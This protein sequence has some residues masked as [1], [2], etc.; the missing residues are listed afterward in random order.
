MQQV[1]RSLCALAFLVVG[2]GPLPERVE[3]L[4]P[5]ASL[6]RQV[7]GARNECAD[8]AAL[9]ACDGCKGR[10]CHRVLDWESH[11]QQA[12]CEVESRSRPQYPLCRAPA[13]LPTIP[14]PP[15]IVDVQCEAECSPIPYPPKAP[16]P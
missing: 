16:F 15:F 12:V 5:C 8:G 3:D 14:P 2:C 11:G 13:P 4:A 1:M 10:L 7:C 9:N 6:R